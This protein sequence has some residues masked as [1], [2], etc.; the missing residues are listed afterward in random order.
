MREARE[1]PIAQPGMTAWGRAAER[2]L[3]AYGAST[4]LRAPEDLTERVMVALEAEMPSRRASW[5][6]WLPRAS[7]GRLQS[8]AGLVAV[9]LMTTAGAALAAAGASAIM[10]GDAAAPTLPGPEQRPV[11]V[12]EPTPTL[13]SDT[14][15]RSPMPRG[16]VEAPKPPPPNLHDAVEATDPRDRHEATE[17]PDATDDIDEPDEPGATDDPD[18]HEGGDEPDETEGPDDV[19][20][21]GGSG[22]GDG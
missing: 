1:A 18:D 17:P 7:S 13:E 22:E 5:L 10:R 6:G 21:S 3:E 20:S 8:A 4:A 19:G 15:D 2:E 14:D 11:V 16:T 12:A 9:L